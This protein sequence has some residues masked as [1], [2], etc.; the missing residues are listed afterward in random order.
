MFHCQW[1]GVNVG[2]NLACGRAMNCISENASDLDTTNLDPGQ[3]VGAGIGAHSRLVDSWWPQ[4]SQ[5][6]SGLHATLLVHGDCILT[7]VLDLIHR[8][9]LPGHSE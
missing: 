9:L 6:L 2:L 1:F 8:F 5:L 3:L 7:V 4:H